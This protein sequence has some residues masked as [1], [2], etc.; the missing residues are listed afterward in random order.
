MNSSLKQSP[1]VAPGNLRCQHATLSSLQCTRSV[2]GL[3]LLVCIHP[4]YRFCLFPWAGP[5][6]VCSGLLVSIL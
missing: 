5:T 1:F 3:R 2:L 6:C 4:T